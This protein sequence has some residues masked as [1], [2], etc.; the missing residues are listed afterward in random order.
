MAGVIISEPRSNQAIL[1]LTVPPK[2]APAT[3]PRAKSDARGP[4]PSVPA[5]PPAHAAAILFSG[6]EPAWEQ[7]Q[8]EKQS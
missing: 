4:A 8:R 1:M 2:A 5:Q 6:G 3:D 7:G